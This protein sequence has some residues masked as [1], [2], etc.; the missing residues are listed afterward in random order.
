M[1]REKDLIYKGESM[2]S[3][4]SAIGCSESK[5]EELQNQLQSIVTQKNE[6]ELKMEEALQDSGWVLLLKILL[7]SLCL[8]SNLIQL[9]SYSGRKDIKE[10]FQVMASAL[11]K[12]M[13]VME[14]QLNKWK[15]TADEAISLR[16]KAQSLSA[17]LDVKV[18]LYDLDVLFCLRCGF[19][20]QN[21]TQ[22]CCFC[23]VCV[24]SGCKLQQ[25]LK[26]LCSLA[27][28]DML[29]NFLMVS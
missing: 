5:V 27:H 22:F 26:N 20:F 12:E 3:A 18:S 28:L 13:G 2:D 7:M 6:M 17:L 11:T 24:L 9:M 14:S 29:I 10:E 19:S 16:E 8:I 25:H 1:R 23:F 4:R 15:I 21:K